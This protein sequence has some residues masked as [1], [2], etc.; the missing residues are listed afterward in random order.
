MFLVGFTALS[1]LI[2]PGKRYIFFILVLGIVIPITCFGIY[3]IYHGGFFLP[4]SLL[5]KG[6]DS[7]HS[8]SQFIISSLKKIYDSGLIYSLMFVPGVYFFIFPIGREKSLE[9]HSIHLLLFVI[10]CT[11]LAHFLF[12]RLGRPYRYGAYLIALEL[13]FL[14]VIF[15]Q[16]MGSFK[17]MSFYGRLGIVFFSIL[18]YLPVLFRFGATFKNNISMSN[19]RNQQVYMA[20]FL[21]KYFPT[22]TVALNDIGAVA[23]Y[24]DNV[25]I[26]DLVGLANNDVIRYHSGSGDSA[27]LKKYIANDHVK[28]AIVYP[29]W[30]GWLGYT[31]PSAWKMIGSWY[32]KDNYIAG[33][34]RVSFYSIDPAVKDTLTKALESYSSVLPSNVIQEGEFM[35]QAKKRE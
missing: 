22:T 11:C 27:F 2:I 16:V 33:N 6:P 13:M 12:A 29:D 14:P 28:M 5:V 24:N 17:S 20:L 25:R 35:R 7:Y 26:F 1:W 15:S 9:K 21:K 23:F 18:L 19:I 34:S 30:I 31:K 32:L 4:N 10:A 3:S 8:V